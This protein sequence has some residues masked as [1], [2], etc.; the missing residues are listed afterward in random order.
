MISDKTGATVPAAN[1]KVGGR[2]SRRRRG[3]VRR[4]FPSPT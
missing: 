3:W 1:L 2:M 4:G